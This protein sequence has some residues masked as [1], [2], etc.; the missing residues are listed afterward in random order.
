M[1]CASTAF[2]SRALLKPASFRAPLAK[3]N[4]SVVSQ[5][6]LEKPKTPSVTTGTL[7]NER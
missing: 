2:L 1:P 6:I 3:L 7:L 4:G 5:E